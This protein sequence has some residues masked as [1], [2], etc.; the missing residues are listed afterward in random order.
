MNRRK[1]RRH[2]TR[3]SQSNER[4]LFCLLPPVSPVFIRGLLLASYRDQRGVSFLR[5]DNAQSAARE[6]SPQVLATRELPG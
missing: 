1:R 2:E 3:A 5:C 6:N 4:P